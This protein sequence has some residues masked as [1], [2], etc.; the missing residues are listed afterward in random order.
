MELYGELPPPIRAVILAIL[1][2]D[3]VE[4]ACTFQETGRSVLALDT[5]IRVILGW[6]RIIRS[7]GRLEIAKCVSSFLAYIETTDIIPLTVRQTGDRW[8]TLLHCKGR[9]RRTR[10]TITARCAIDWHI[11][12]VS[13]LVREATL[14]LKT[15]SLSLMNRPV[16]HHV[17]E[18]TSA[19]H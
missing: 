1:A 2:G 12:P 8:Q 19:R 13:D 7:H 11:C 6:R 4:V 18:P 3:G 9:L 17:T 10:L 15:Q 5:P 16:S 14:G